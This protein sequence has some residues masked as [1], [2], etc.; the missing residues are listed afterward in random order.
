MYAYRWQLVKVSGVERA[1]DVDRDVVGALRCW[2]I[3]RSGL[4]IGFCQSKPLLVSTSTYVGLR[5][6]M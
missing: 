4:D 5:L 3:A 6:Y 1:W 2:L